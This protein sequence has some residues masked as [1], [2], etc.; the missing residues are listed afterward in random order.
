[1]AVSPY[2]LKKL[3]EQ[4]T[5]LL[6]KL[7][8]CR[9]DMA[10]AMG[11]D[12]GKSMIEPAS[13]AIKQIGPIRWLVPMMIH[14]VGVGILGANAFTGK[15]YFAIQLAASV[16]SGRNL[17]GAFNP[18]VAAPV[19]YLYGE[20]NRS[21]FLW[22]LKQHLQAR[23][24]PGDNLFVKADRIPASEMKI[25]MPS[26]E[27]IVHS[28]KAKLLILDTLAFYNAGD[29]SNEQIQAKLIEP[30]VELV[31]R[32]GCFALLLTHSQKNAAEREGINQ[33][34]GGT[35]LVGAADVVLRMERVKGEP[36]DSKLRTLIAEKVRGAMS[37]EA[38]LEMDFSRKTLF[39]Q[40]QDPREVLYPK[41]KFEAMRAKDPWPGEV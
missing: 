33:I 37:W 13:E 7:D 28:S 35:A 18:T 34:R 16:A 36:R 25:G 24:I 32:C 26:L 9:R 8:E 19:C 39:E 10:V 2:L 41:E 17:F 5:Q 20:S 27:A 40:G 4:E 38:T 1:M 11:E 23:G 30:L 22:G 15:S 31:E 3:R 6:A 14:S 29:E 12:V 21:E